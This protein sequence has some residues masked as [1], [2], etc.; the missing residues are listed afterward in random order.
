MP[1]YEKTVNWVKNRGSTKIKPKLRTKHGYMQKVN[2]ISVMTLIIFLMPTFSQAQQKG[3]ADSMALKKKLFSEMNAAMDSDK[4]F[5][6]PPDNSVR[7][8]GFMCRQEW[9]LEKA[10]RLPIRV[11]LGSLDYV[12]KME[13]KKQ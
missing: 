5:L 10:T 1:Y 4:R 13:G 9:K 11:R 8:L 2:Q 3:P 7:Q 12:N 6:L